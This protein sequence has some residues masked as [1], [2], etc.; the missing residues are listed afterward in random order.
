VNAAGSPGD[1]ELLR[2]VG[3]LQADAAGSHPPPETLVAYHGRHLAGAAADALQE[4]LAGCPSCTAVL[5]DLAAFDDAA[6][7]EEAAATDEEPSAAADFAAAAEWRALRGRLPAEAAAGTAA[8]R[9]VRVSHRPA[10]WVPW[11]AA[12]ALALVA[13]GLGFQVL[14]LDRRADSLQARLDTPQAD[15]PIVYLDAVTRDEEQAGDAEPL[16]PDGGVLLVVVTP[17]EPEAYAAYTL[18]V[19]DATGARHTVAGL[20]PSP[21]YGTLRAALPRDALSAGRLAVTLFGIDDDGER[22]EV[23]RYSFQL[24]ER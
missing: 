1:R 10:A 7:D 22:H 20:H 14:R 21:R 16:P 9:P 23:A 2:L 19:E 18:A 8:E 11:A 15:V 13:F 6:G 4:H 17:E 5:L 12:A 3:E 24:A